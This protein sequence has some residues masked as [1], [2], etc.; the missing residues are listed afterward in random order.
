[1]DLTLVKN[2]LRVDINDDDEYLK[3][4]IEVAKE[5]IIAAIGKCDESKPRVKL[6]MLNIISN[7]YETRQFTVDKANEKVQYALKT[8]ITQLQIE[9]EM[10]SGDTIA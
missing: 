10:G 6:L 1:M 2:F 3:L 7:L 8:M 4:L 9:A 5:Y